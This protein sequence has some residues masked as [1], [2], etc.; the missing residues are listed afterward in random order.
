MVAVQ[1]CSEEELLVVLDNGK[2]ANLLFATQSVSEGIIITTFDNSAGLACGVPSKVQKFDFDH[3]LDAVI[4]KLEDGSMGIIIKAL[5]K[6]SVMVMRGEIPLDR[7]QQAERWCKMVMDRAYPE[8]VKPRRLKILINP[9]S[10]TSKARSSFDRI[11]R[12]ILEAAGCHLDI[13]LTE[14]VNHARDI[15]ESL[16]I[17]NYD[18]LICVSGD[19]LIH[20]VINGFARRSDALDALRLPLGIIPSGSGNALCTN[21]VGPHQVDD[22]AVSALNVLKG[23]PLPIDVLSITQGDRRFYSFLTQAFGKMADVDVGTDH[24][25]WLGSLRFTLAYIKGSIELWSYACQLAMHVIESD[26]PRLIDGVLSF[27]P[28]KD[29]PI[30]DSQSGPMPKLRYGTVNDPLPTDLPGWEIS[31]GRL[32]TVYAG[33]FPYVARDVLQFPAARSDGLIDVVV[34]PAN[35]G[36][37]AMLGIIDGSDKGK[38]FH[39]YG[40]H[41]YKVDCYRLTPV[42]EGP[43]APRPGKKTLVGHR[44]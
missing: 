20:E 9:V 32:T 21:I 13:L 23:R 44:W 1:S 10:G 27:D 2:P 29:P 28:S 5:E 39:H 7:L 14:R 34:Q 43:E 37:M 30:D 12:P 16:D 40:T 38:H 19:G 33:K 8:V 22:V 18:A 24:Q 35:L 3:V 41:Y 25:R 11:V 17:T 4:T 15:A 42:V 31:D 26:K 36:R 6:Q